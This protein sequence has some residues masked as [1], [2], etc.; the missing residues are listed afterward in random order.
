ISGNAQT[1]REHCVLQHGTLLLGVDVDKMFSLLKVPNEKIRDKMISTVKERVTSVKDQ[2]GREIEFSE[3][4]QAL[5]EGFEK[6]LN[7]K[8]EKG[9]LSQS[10]LEMAE[11]IAQDKYS[12][13]DWNFKR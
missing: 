7:I 4:S 8:L 3:I 6:A 12:N 2:L 10:E 5:I 1:R 11:K 9:Q 13:K